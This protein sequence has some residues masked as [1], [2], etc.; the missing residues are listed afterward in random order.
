MKK[1]FL[2][3]LMLI[4][5][6]GVLFSCDIKDGKKPPVDFNKEKNEV[7]ND[8]NFDVEIPYTE[9]NDVKRIP[10][11]L[12][13][14]SMDM[15]F[16][17]GCSEVLISLAEVLIMQKNGKISESDFI[18][19]SGSTIADGSVYETAVINIAEIEIGG[20]D[21][22]VLRDVKANVAPDLGAPILLGNGVIDQVASVEI[23]NMN[24]T[25]KFKRQ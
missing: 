15:I 22:I 5:A 14:V 18:G 24:K 20:K 23:D 17:T 12:N 6:F 10:V 4:V 13:G 25:I 11:K 3:S 7:N 16:D 19:S 1:I 2:K 9:S 21:G 8:V